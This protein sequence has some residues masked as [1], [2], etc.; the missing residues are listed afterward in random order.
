[1]LM[2]QHISSLTL[3]FVFVVLQATALNLHN[4]A[5]ENHEHYPLHGDVAELGFYDYAADESESKEVAKDKTEEE[6][7]DAWWTNRAEQE[8]EKP[9]L[10]KTEQTMHADWWM[11]SSDTKPQVIILAG[12]EGA[13]HDIIQAAWREFFPTGLNVTIVP[14]MDK[15]LCNA[16]WTSA[17]IDNLVTR[18]KRIETGKLSTLPQLE[19][20]RKCALDKKNDHENQPRLDMIVDAARRANVGL[21]VL[22]LHRSLEGCLAASCLHNPKN[23]TE[24]VKKLNANAKYLT[25]Q[26]K[27]VNPSRLSCFEYGDMMNIRNEVEAAFNSSRRGAKILDDLSDEA[28]TYFT[29]QEDSNWHEYTKSLLYAD[30]A[31][32]GVCKAVR[33]FH[34]T[35]LQKIVTGPL[36]WKNVQASN[37]TNSLT[38]FNKSAHG[39]KHK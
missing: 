28:A 14:L 32:Q 26:L 31:I 8:D 20:H 4:Q 3:V 33:K 22:M 38:R 15:W 39:A 21:R 13:G 34:L 16:N 35:D 1:M 6:A 5:K 11:N 23:C 7:E 29:K 30:R 24:Q 2:E 9:N 27:T 17:D 36:N 25:A 19:S 18:M 10:F 12:L 37:V